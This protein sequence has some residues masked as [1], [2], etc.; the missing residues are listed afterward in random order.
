MVNTEPFSDE[1]GLRR[2]KFL[3]PE[4]YEDITGGFAMQSACPSP[5]L[6]EHHAK[7]WCFFVLGRNLPEVLPLFFPSPT[8]LSYYFHSTFLF[9]PGTFS[10]SF[11]S[12]I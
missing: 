10:S 7:A 11:P 3:P 4:D 1:V 5:Q 12:I 2:F 9:F 6:K 8:L